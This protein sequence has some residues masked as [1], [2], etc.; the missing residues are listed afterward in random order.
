MVVHIDLYTT[1]APL[2]L[3]DSQ[4]GVL[5]TST[6]L[7]TLDVRQLAGSRGARLLI[8]PASYE[9]L[10]VTATASGGAGV[11]VSS[12]LARGFSLSGEALQQAFAGGSSSVGGGILFRS[13][14]VAS[15]LLPANIRRVRAPV[16]VFIAPSSLPP[17]LRRVLVVVP[18]DPRNAIAGRI[19]LRYAA[20]MVAG[21]AQV[22]VLLLL[23]LMCFNPAPASAVAFAVPPGP[24]ST[25]LDTVQ[26]I[27]ATTNPLVDSTVT[28]SAAASVTAA[29]PAATATPTPLPPPI[30]SPSI[31]PPVVGGEKALSTKARQALASALASVTHGGS[32]PPNATAIDAPANAPSVFLS[33]LTPEGMGR[34]EAANALLSSHIKS[35]AAPST[36]SVVGGGGSS[37]VI[38]RVQSSLDHGASAVSVV[39]QVCARTVR[40]GISA[41]VYVL[42][43]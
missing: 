39:L 38:C 29:I 43:L 19:L 9:P 35:N 11:G 27:R 32:A 33:L 24:P 5:E 2:L 16:A 13:A 23:P 22:T 28:P 12:V 7:V 3:S 36:G 26:A 10:S 34:Y 25:A 17:V 31:S 41:G 42:C 20:A 4:L 21:G 14:A 30:P 6:D 15:L 37:T 18:H 40:L 1:H 8:L